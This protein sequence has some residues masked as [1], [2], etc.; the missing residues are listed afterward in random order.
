[1]F[2]HATIDVAA[3][4]KIG[5]WP[6]PEHHVGVA[7]TNGIEVNHQQWCM[8]CAQ[9]QFGIQNPAGGR[10]ASG[11]WKYLTASNVAAFLLGV[12]IVILVVLIM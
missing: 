10:R 3:G 5:E 6:S 9:E 12:S 8:T 4:A 2:E 1:M 7:P 11:G